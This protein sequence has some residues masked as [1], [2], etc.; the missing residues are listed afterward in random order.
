[1]HPP[2]ASEEQPTVGR[3]GVLAA[4]EVFEHG[5]AG[6]TTAADDPTTIPDRATICRCNGVTKGALVR[7]WGSGARG[8]ADL[9]RATRATTG[10]G[11][12]TD[13]V[14]GIAAWLTSSDADA[15]T[16][17]P[18]PGRAEPGDPARPAPEPAPTG[19]IR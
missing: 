10:C 3:H 11:T 13:A 1:M 5:R 9:A 19:G 8:A 15:A 14:E 16:P 2:G 18:V 12:C 7:A 6:S 4:K 17:V